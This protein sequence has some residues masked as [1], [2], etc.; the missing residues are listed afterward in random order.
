MKLEMVDIVGETVLRPR[1]EPFFKNEHHGQEPWEIDRQVMVAVF[2][3][4]KRVVLGND[5]E[6][7]DWD[8]MYLREARARM[9]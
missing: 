9:N 3:W 2:E 1:W 5:H 7:Q 4:R 8:L 6:D